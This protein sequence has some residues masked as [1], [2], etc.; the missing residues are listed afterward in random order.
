MDLSLCFY[1][2]EKKQLLNSNSHTSTFR[3]NYKNDFF[4]DNVSI[5]QAKVQNNLHQIYIPYH[6]LFVFLRRKNIE[7]I[8]F[9]QAMIGTNSYCDIYIK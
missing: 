5:I 2:R 1:R 9:L 8:L 6:G 3:I 4:I 7:Q